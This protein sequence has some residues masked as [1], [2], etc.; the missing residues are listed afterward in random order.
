MKHFY[1][2]TAAW[3]QWLDARVNYEKFP[4]YNYRLNGYRRLLAALGDPQRRL[5][6]VILI[7]G[8][9]G[10]GSTAAIIDACLQA[11]GYQVG[12][13]SSPHLLSI[14]ERIMV[15]R[16]P[17]SDREF[18]ACIARLR[19]VFRHRRRVGARTFF[20]AVTAA[21]FMHFAQRQTD[22]NLLEVGLGGRRDAT[23]VSQ[24]LISVITRIGYDHTNLLGTH[25]A[26]I[27]YEKAGIMKPAGGS[28]KI[29]VTNRQ[30]PAVMKIIEQEARKTGT[31][32]IRA[33]QVHQVKI[34]KAELSSTTFEIQGALGCF[35]ARLSMAGY[36]QAENLSIS[37]AV[38]H[39]IK[40]NGYQIKISAI[41]E[42]LQNAYLAGRFEVLNRHPLII[43]DAAHNEDSFRALANN[44]LLLRGRRIFFVFGCS[45]DKDI[46]YCL[47]NLFLRADAVLLVK[48]DH[49][50][51]MDPEA[52]RRRW[53]GRPQAVETAG[54][55]AKALTVLETRIGKQPAVPAAIIV[56]GSFY[57]YADTKRWLAKRFNSFSAC[58]QG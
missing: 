51:A 23:N 50:R 42:G 5:R 10:K 30:R 22:F 32:I 1:S 12:R 57:L 16:Q 8:T 39:E 35:K 55:I 45:Q 27:A 36:H 4:A 13:Y 19:F 48:A 2:Q 53:H 25:L 31:N 52:I 20:E 37:L 17:I 34:I 21:A 7:A 9:K 44:L 58:Q 3:R 33:D 40:K 14:N 49:P 47:R 54:S 41:T 43:Y 24:P 46:G 38:L 26:D 6:N 28:S 11:H 56:F 15:N 18:A 29:L